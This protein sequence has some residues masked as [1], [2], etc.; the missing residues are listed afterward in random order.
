M[1]TSAEPSAEIPPHSP[2]AEQDALGCILLAAGPSS[3]TRIFW[4]RCLIVV[5]WLPTE[6]FWRAAA[7]RCPARNATSK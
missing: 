7:W 5:L 4:I 2:E 6:I 1:G 3:A